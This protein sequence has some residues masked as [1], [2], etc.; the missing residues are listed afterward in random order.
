MRQ[1][2]VRPEFRDKIPPL[3]ADEYSRLEANILEDGEVREPIVVWGNV[4]I[5]GHNRWKIVQA[6]PE[7]PF[8][9]KEMNFSDEWDAIAWMCRNQLGR[10]NLSDKQYTY[11]LGK[12]AEA[13]ANTSCFT[14]NNQHTPKELLHQSDVEAPKRY[15][16]APVIAKEHGIS[17]SKVIKAK[18]FSQGIDMAETISPGIK[19]DILSGKINVPK[20]TVSSIRNIPEEERPAAVDAI[21]RGD[22]AAAFPPK[23]SKSTNPEGY[24][25]K[26]REENRIISDVVSGLYDEGRVVVRTVDRLLE[27]L[28]A[29]TKDFIGKV[30]RSLEIFGEALNEAGAREKV[31]AALE[32][33]EGEVEKIRRGMQ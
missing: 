30:N 16:I 27:D 28:E 12:E 19:D 1:L 31:D 33:F 15:G 6:H 3:S 32:A 22:A 20:S 14:G 23:K 7:I 9:V 29:L 24:S 4:I 11:I 13:R 18:G 17:E 25:Q 26:M 21:K 8:E 2:E 5:D 10:R